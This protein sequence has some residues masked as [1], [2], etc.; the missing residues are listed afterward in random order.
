MSIHRRDL[1]VRGAASSAAL[2]AAAALADA[3][4]PAKQ[5]PPTPRGKAPP[6]LGKHEPAALPFKPGSLTG[7]SEKMITAHHDKNYAGAVKNLNKVETELAALKPDAP[8]YLVAALRDKQLT[9]FNSMVLHEQYFGNL[10]GNGKRSGALET[11]LG[12]DFGAGAWEAQVRAAAMGLG[13]GS[14]WVILG[15]SMHDGSLVIWAGG[16]HTQTL[17]FGAP[18]MALDMYEHAYQQD[19]GPD[20]AAYIDAFFKNLAWEVVEARY[21]RAMRALAVLG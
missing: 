12:H 9:F 17:A 4:P 11:R 14:G 18:L 10:G 13:G 15:L 6:G 20:H 19:Y 16:N 5:G 2:L 7:I 3:A 21:D 1:L 8:A